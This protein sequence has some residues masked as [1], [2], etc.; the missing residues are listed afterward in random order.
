M[1]SFKKHVL[2]N[3][4]RVVL[5]P[6]PQ[7]LAAAA[8]VSV[9]SGSK[10]E[11][12]N[13]NGISHF[14]EHMCFK[15]TKKRPT[16][17]ALSSEMESLGAVFNAF[18]GHELTGYFAKVSPEKID[19]AL[20]IV[21]DLYL[22]PIF[23]EKEFEKEKGVIIEEIN[24][25]EDLPMKKVQD[26]FLELVYGDQPAGRPVIGDKAI[27]RSMTRQNLLAY[28]QIHYVP[29]AT[30]V[31]VA[32]AFDKKKM[33]K[34]IEKLFGAIP[35]GEKSGK[36]KVKE[37]QKIPQTLLYFK[38]S[39]QTHLVL[40]LRTFDMYDERKYALAI[41]GAILEGGMS[42]RLFQSV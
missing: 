30:A 4:L 38:E 8:L 34:R 41:L 16:T 39:D 7:S 33:L 31:I 21:S 37:S 35:E 15:G 3:G 12:K 29:K 5:I 26:L 2:K 18:T 20:E 25:Y 40:G 42:S 14:L 36:E 11:T 19:N 1:Q 10:Y 6:S 23:N 17:L 22:N 32:G 27:I 9:E 13:I 24:M 28:R